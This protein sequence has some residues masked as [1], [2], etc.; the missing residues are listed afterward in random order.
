[1]SEAEVVRHL[2]CGFRQ[3]STPLEVRLRVS[4]DR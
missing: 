2:A 1:M 4:Y 3:Q